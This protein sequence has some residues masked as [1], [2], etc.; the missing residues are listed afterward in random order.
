MKRIL[1]ALV[2]GGLLVVPFAAQASVSAVGWWTRNP[3]ATAPEGGAQVANG[4]DG[5]VSYAGVRTAASGDTIATALLSFKEADGS[6]NG[7]G[8]T[9]DACPAVGS[10]KPGQGTL[11]DGPQADCS[12][13]RASLSRDA[14]G[15]WSGDV[16]S[17]LQGDSPAVALVPA[18]DAGV[19]QVTFG[20]P[21]L[22]VT[23]KAPPTSS[24][25]TGGS[26]G[27]DSS[28]FTSSGSSGSGS[29]S[30]GSSGSSGGSEFSAS[31][32]ASSFDASG[33]S[34]QVA[35]AGSLDADAA[36]GG[37]ETDPGTAESASPE[38]AGSAVDGPVR[39]LTASTGA[40]DN[41]NK[42]LQFAFFVTLAAG[43]GTGA[44]FARNQ[45]S[46]RTT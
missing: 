8:A 34:S 32:G 40:E 45:L 1:I 12:L 27:F 33:P 31:G 16:A 6:V 28:E 22:A 20:P 25:G 2:V 26:S 36:A 18:E 4:P 21:S 7:A 5:V 3:A 46:K 17:V 38:L 42:L 41:G 9:I 14:A 10:W 35:T 23:T 24:S 29:G 43:I 15:G 37:A 11:F 30:L 13:G 19:F 44:G 39:A